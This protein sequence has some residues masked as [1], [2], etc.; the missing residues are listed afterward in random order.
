[1]LLALILSPV[2]A[3]TLA[4]Y[5]EHGA[6]SSIECILCNYFQ[7]RT[8]TPPPIGNDRLSGAHPDRLRET[9]LGRLKWPLW[10]RAAAL[11]HSAFRPFL[12]FIDSRNR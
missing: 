7:R 8:W 12:V 1:M 2:S 3:F 9:H 11:V 10:A 5:G 4:L 6:R